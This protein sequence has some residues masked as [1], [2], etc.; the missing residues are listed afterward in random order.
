MSRQSGDEGIVTGLSETKNVDV[1]S[2][3]AINDRKNYIEASG[4]EWSV[5]KSLP[6]S[7]SI[8]YG[9]PDRDRLIENYKISL[10]NLGKAG[11]KTVCYNFMP[12]LDWARTELGHE[13]EDG[14]ISL[15]VN[16]VKFVNFDCDILQRDG[17]ETDYSKKEIKAAA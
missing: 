16:K 12:V 2:L 3:D 8:K 1:W 7:E 13:W 14:D 10:A 9:G 4:L 5:V 11:V 6:E 17:A 15:F